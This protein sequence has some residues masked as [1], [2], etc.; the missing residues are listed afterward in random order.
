[1]SPRRRCF[2]AVDKTLSYLYGLLGQ[3][4]GSI[5]PWGA[6][7]P[8]NIHGQPMLIAEWLM[9]LHHS[10]PVHAGVERH[11]VVNSNFDV[12]IL[13]A[14]QRGSWKLSIDS[15]HFSLLAIWCPNNPGQNPS[16]FDQRSKYAIGDAA[17]END[18]K[19]R[20]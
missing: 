7:H 3:T 17:Q 14:D 16:A 9:I 10:V 11:L 20:R 2:E 18:I 6:L 5:R 1:M 4:R 13:V 12:I 8:S 15:D 19:P